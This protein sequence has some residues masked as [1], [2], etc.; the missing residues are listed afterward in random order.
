[1]LFTCN[2]NIKQV[3]ESTT[4]LQAVSQLLYFYDYHA[5]QKI[6]FVFF[7]NGLKDI[8][9][10]LFKDKL[11]FIPAYSIPLPL[12][13]SLFLKNSKFLYAKFYKE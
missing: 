7:S 4:K 3:M 11:Y 6:L 10:T 2:E 9:K 1:M 12:L 13:T 8:K 5:L